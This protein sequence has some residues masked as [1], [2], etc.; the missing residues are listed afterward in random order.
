MQC[1]YKNIFM[2]VTSICLSE[3]GLYGQGLYPNSTATDK[4]KSDMRKLNQ[5]PLV[6][7]YCFIH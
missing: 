4:E 6:L 2:V 3:K 1:D 5:A 7:A